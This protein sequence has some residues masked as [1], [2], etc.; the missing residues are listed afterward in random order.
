[1]KKESNTKRLYY[2]AI[3][4]FSIL[5]IGSVLLSVIDA[6]GSYEEYANLSFPSWIHY[7]L[8]IAKTLG[9]I[10]ILTS[11]SRRLKDFAFAGFLYDI[12][13]AIG[14]HLYVGELYVIVAFTGLVIWIFAFIM[15]RKYEL[16]AK[17]LIVE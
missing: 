7:P 10:V 2:V 16:S 17:K 5:F 3:I 8:V 14:G 1:M 6:E 12:L 15:D 11:K 4:L 13:L 9:V